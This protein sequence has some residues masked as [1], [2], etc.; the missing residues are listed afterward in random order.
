VSGKITLR[1]YSA[2][3]TDVFQQA[4]HSETE[5]LQI[6]LQTKS[7]DALETYLQ[8]YLESPK[9]NEVLNDIAGVKRSDFNEWTMF[10]VSNF[11][12]PIYI[13]ISSI[14]QIGDEVAVSVKSIWDTSAPNQQFP[15]VAYVDEL[16]LYDCKRPMMAYAERTLVSKSGQTLYHYKWADPKFL[17]LSVGTAIAPGTVSYSIQNMLCHEQ[18]RTPLIGKKEL[19]AMKYPS[20]SS[21]AAGD[22]DIFYM[23]IQNSMNTA[24]QKEVVVIFK[25]HRDT[26]FK[27]PPKISLPEPLYYRTELDDVLL[28][29]DENKYY[30][31]W[32]NNFHAANNLVFT[33]GPNFSKEIV[34][35]DFQGSSPYGVLQRIVCKPNEA[36]K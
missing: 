3:D 24:N 34:W 25:M 20:V 18:T 12:F 17:D 8:K 21:T 26:E 23:P 11:H 2:A 32:S 9:R 5:D 1:P 28:K 30:S 15:D 10:E 6:A 27:L 19:A 14:Q 31:R 33:G 36:Q 4:K 29:C 13:K 16:T 7:I 35:T 22:G